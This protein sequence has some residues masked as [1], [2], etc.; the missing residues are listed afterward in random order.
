M[1][2]IKYGLKYRQNE[3]TY[4]D[5][6]VAGNCVKIVNLLKAAVHVACL[7][8][9]HFKIIVLQLWDYTFQLQA[10]SSNPMKV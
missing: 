7:S 3:E 9:T 4:H 1:S 8:S 6:V 10:L 5:K 2:K